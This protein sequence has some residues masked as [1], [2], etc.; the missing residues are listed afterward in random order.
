MRSS[1]KSVASVGVQSHQGAESEPDRRIDEISH[2]SGP[3]FRGPHSTK[4]RKFS[5]RNA[6]AAHKQVINASLTAHVK[7]P[8]A[9]AMESLSQAA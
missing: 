3:P 9:G 6:H 8:T 2:V 5:I 4:S 1:S 7:N